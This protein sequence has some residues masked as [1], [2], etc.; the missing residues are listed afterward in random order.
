MEVGLKLFFICSL[1]MVLGRFERTVLT[2]YSSCWGP[3]W[4]HSTYTLQSLYGSPLKAY[5]LHIT[6]AVGGHSKSKVLTH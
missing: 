2:H 1:E 3:L 4:Q 6:V 5:H